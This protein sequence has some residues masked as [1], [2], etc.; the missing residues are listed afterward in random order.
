M[1][2]Q[3]Y[4]LYFGR[5]VVPL[6][7]AP[8]V[9]WGIS[10]ALRSRAEIGASAAAVVAALLLGFLIWQALEYSIH[11]FVFHQEPSSYWGVTVGVPLDHHVGRHTLFVF[12]SGSA[13]N[14]ANAEGSSYM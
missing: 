7:W 4:H 10:T 14:S 5:W 11:R 8:V 9:A 3:T 2:G 6:V 13:S 12:H 1:I